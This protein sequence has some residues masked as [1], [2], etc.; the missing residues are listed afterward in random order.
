MKFDPLFATQPPKDFPV[1]VKQSCCQ[2][3][4]G[5]W[6]VHSLAEWE[7][8]VRDMAS[9]FT[10]TQLD[11]RKKFYAKWLQQFGQKDL[12]D[13]WEEM[14]LFHVEP[15]LQGREHQIEVVVED[16]ELLI[17]DT[18]DLLKRDD[19]LVMFVTPGSFELPEDWAH[20]VAGKLRDLGY[21]NQAMDIEF[22]FTKDGPQLVEI[23]SRY[24]YM[25]WASFFE[26]QCEDGKSVLQ[27]KPD[28]RNLENRTLS[29]IGDPPTRFPSDEAC[30]SKLAIMMYT[31][32]TGPLE[33]I[34]DL[35]FLDEHVRSG[36]A[37]AWAPKLPFLQRYVS[38]DDL[39]YSGKWCKLGCLLMT[40]QRLDFEATNAKIAD[41]Q[42]KFF[43][44]GSD[45]YIVAQDDE[46]GYL[47]DKDAIHF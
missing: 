12:A 22:V 16:H 23:N 21:K 5:T 42:K 18:G 19:I 2:F 31:Q 29:C 40:A 15:Y 20:D 32:K 7:L 36:S 14:S 30:I 27:K 39:R 38:E 28:I 6:I 4:V 24:S 34:V 46:M 26:H 10:R 44:S 43:R 17:A 33:E 13:G 41:F 25:G 35:E 8:L 1:V 9:R 11:R 45:S 3:Y 37:E 47:V